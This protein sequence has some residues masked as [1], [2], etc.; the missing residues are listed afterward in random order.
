MYIIKIDSCSFSILLVFRT[1]IIEFERSILYSKIIYY[2]VFKQNSGEFYALVYWLLYYLISMSIPSSWLRC[3]KMSIWVNLT[4]DAISL[5]EI[6]WRI[7]THKICTS[8]WNVFL[9]DVSAGF[10]WVDKLIQTWQLFTLYDNCIR[11]IP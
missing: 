9:N 10:S 6:N 8:H 5:D 11:M 4:T 3:L 2:M 1:A 7:F